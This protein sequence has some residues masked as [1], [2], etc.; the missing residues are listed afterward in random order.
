M[1]KVMLL[2]TSRPFAV[3][4]LLLLVAAVWPDQRK[5][6]ERWCSRWQIDGRRSRAYS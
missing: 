2:R 4:G 1:K 3:R 5:V 6:S